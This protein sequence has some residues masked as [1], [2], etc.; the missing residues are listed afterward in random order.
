MSHFSL[1]TLSNRAV[2]TFRR[3]PLPLFS[4]LAATSS[5]ICV[6][7]VAPAGHELPLVLRL[8]M[9]FY[10][11]MLLTISVSLFT[12]RFAIKHG[13]KWLVWSASIGLIALY[14]LALPSVMDGVTMAHFAL[15]TVALH[16]L[17]AF[18]PFVVL[19]E[20]NGLWQYNKTLFIRILISGV[21]S[22][23][24]YAGLALAVLAVEK[25][26]EVRIDEKFYVD[27]W[28]I[29]AGIFNTWFFLSGVPEHIPDLEHTTDYPKGLKIFTL[30]VLLPLITVYLVILYA[31]AGKILIT[32]DWPVGWVANLVIAF[33][34]FGILS[35]LLIY[36]LRNDEA[37]PWVK[38]YSRLFY[39]L[40]VPLIAL[41]Y[42]SIFKRIGMYGVTVERYYVVLLAAWLSFIAGY[43]ILTSGKRIRVI[44][45]SLCVI[46]LFSL[47]GPWGAF[48]I[49]RESQIAE[50]AALLDSNHILVNGKV[51]STKTHEVRAEDY[52]RIESIVNYLG[53]MHGRKSL[54]LF[55]DQ[56]I[57]SVMA[58]HHVDEYLTQPRGL[59]IL[60]AM[61]VERID[62]GN[63]SPTLLSY[64]TKD[65]VML[66]SEGYDLVTEFPRADYSGNGDTTTAFLV[67]ADT[68]HMAFS[69]AQESFELTYRDYE[70]LVLDLKELLAS[71]PNHRDLERTADRMTILADHPKWKAKLILSSLE[72][73]RE[74][75]TPNLIAAKGVLMLRFT[76]ETD[77][78]ATQVSE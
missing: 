40:L 65:R 78:A 25:L 9:A 50:L 19:N 29:I 76:Q 44:P 77:H 56:N 33:S 31:Y 45:L 22:G 55:F 28:L 12:E 3:F 68:V 69:A 51:D 42:V 36:P 47:F 2:E 7:H 38:F 48:A 54:Q 18:A 43:F 58:Q 17:V 66:S 23:V 20:M 30:Y 64:G 27:L 75:G 4:A 34:I 35:F 73:S 41:L 6:V 46:V 62:S 26:F 59:D 63:G 8:S 15:L 72:I 5:M 11:S 14:F 67:E 10:L 24:L 49:S 57:D 53:Q 16:L 52:D 70:P 74:K 1:I 60:R 37:T 39:F 13:K 21:Y 61:K 32:A 71:L